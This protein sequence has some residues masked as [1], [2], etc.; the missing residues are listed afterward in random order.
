MADDAKAGQTEQSRRVIEAGVKKMLA[1]AVVECVVR[2]R[3]RA[4]RLIDRNTVEAISIRSALNA[5]GSICAN[6]FLTME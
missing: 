5:C 6:A 4:R 1:A 3:E 2:C